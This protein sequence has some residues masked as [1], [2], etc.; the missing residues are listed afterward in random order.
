LLVLLALFVMLGFLMATNYYVSTH[1]DRLSPY[2]PASAHSYK[3]QHLL[4]RLW[5]QL[6]CLVGWRGG[7]QEQ[8]AADE[9]IWLG[10]QQLQVSAV[11]ACTHTHCAGEHNDA[12]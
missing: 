10:K 4:P 3:L 9:W 12:K 7:G 6:Y 2:Q 1:A 5:R 11:I 8:A